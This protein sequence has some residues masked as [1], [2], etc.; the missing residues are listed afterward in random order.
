MNNISQNQQQPDSKS[1]QI[2]PLKNQTQPIEIESDLI[3][4]VF[5]GMLIYNVYNKYLSGNLWKCNESFEGCKDSS[6]I[7]NNCSLNFTH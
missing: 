7:V 3:L 1:K 6:N 4:Y 5:G 2:Q